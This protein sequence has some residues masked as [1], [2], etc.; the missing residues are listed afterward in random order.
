MKQPLLMTIIYASLFFGGFA[1]GVIAFESSYLTN[2]IGEIIATVSWLSMLLTG[3]LGLLSF[4]QFGESLDRK[5]HPWKYE[6]TLERNSC[7]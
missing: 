4:R 2:A 6:T 5:K 1:F 3:V 7:D